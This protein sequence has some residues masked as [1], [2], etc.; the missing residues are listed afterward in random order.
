M[1]KTKTVV[2]EFNT[3][4]SELIESVGDT[5]ATIADLTN[6]QRDIQNTIIAIRQNDSNKYENRKYDYE[7]FIV[8]ERYNILYI[9]NGLVELKYA[10]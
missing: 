9:K 6:A 3:E 5:Q 4:V 1:N 7:L 2:F 8:E 10:R